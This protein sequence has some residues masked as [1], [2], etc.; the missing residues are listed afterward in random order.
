MNNNNMK[1]CQVLS[2]SLNAMQ[3]LYLILIKA[4]YKNG[5]IILILQVIK[6]KVRE[7]NLPKVSKLV[8]DEEWAM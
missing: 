3:I 5:V 7:I 2:T 4:I 6:L 8:R 1:A